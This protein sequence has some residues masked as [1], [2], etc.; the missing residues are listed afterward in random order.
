MSLFT[1]TMA[2]VA[3]LVHAGLLAALAISFFDVSILPFFLFAIALKMIPEF[4]LL[5]SLSI[6]F[7]KKNLLWLFLPAQ[8]GYLFYITIIG[9]ASV[10]GSYHW[11]GREIKTSG[12]KIPA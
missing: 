11:K 7:G 3:Y 2:T 6:F 5:N 1:V 12:M 9:A 4:F 8:I 10:A